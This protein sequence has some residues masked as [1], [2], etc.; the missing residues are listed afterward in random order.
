MYDFGQTVNVSGP[1]ER[2]SSGILETCVIDSAHVVSCWGTDPNPGA[3]GPRPDIPATQVSV[4][5]FGCLLTEE[6]T[7]VCWGEDELGELDAPSGA[8][9]SVSTGE[10][11][12]CA[13]D[14]TGAAAC[15]GESEVGWAIEPPVAARFTKVAA[16][17]EATCGL[18]DEGAIRCWGGDSDSV[19]WLD[20][21]GYEPDGTF[22]DVALGRDLAC[23]VRDDG[24]VLCW[25]GPFG[26]PSDFP[27]I[28][29]PLFPSE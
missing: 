20:I 26:T 25:G 17:T 10:R 7:I 5:G 13:L 29:D 12:A 21:A 19:D 28:D 24:G 2:V 3:P 1:F 9:A 18:T 4:N 11:H 6:E 27:P 15:W 23:G 16:G 22:T 14:A 8:F